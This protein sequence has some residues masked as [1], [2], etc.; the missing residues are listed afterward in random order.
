M[1]NILRTIIGIVLGVSSCVAMQYKVQN[2]DEQLLKGGAACT[3]FGAQG[4]CLGFA[5]RADKLL[6]GSY[7]GKELKVLYPRAYRAV[8]AGLEQHI[9]HIRTKYPKPSERAFDAV[10]TA[11]AQLARKETTAQG[12]KPLQGG[13]K[14]VPQKF[15]L[16]L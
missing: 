8:T 3:Y 16:D 11:E 1:K 15:V 10:R 12:I 14:R 4:A 6:I 2:I 7:C 9:A 5:R 13:K